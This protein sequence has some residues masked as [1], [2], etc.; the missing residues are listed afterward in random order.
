MTAQGDPI[1]GMEATLRLATGGLEV[2]KNETVLSAVTGCSVVV[3]LHSPTR[4]CGGM[5]HFSA[6]KAKNHELTTQHGNGAILELARRMKS[7]DCRSHELQ[8]QIIGGASVP[9]MKGCASRPNIKIAERLLKKFGVKV[10][11]TDT[12]GHLGRKVVFNT[13]TGELV[14]MKTANLRQSDWICRA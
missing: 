6:P 14:V 13:N 2:A 12:G 9:G 10:V 11:S 5:C 8:A 4:R 7:L 1:K 3:T